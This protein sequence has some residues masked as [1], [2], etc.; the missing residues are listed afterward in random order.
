M[1]VWSKNLELNI[2]II[3]KQHKEIFE[4]VNKLLS[5]FEEHNE[6]EETYKA[7][8]FVEEYIRKHFQT[9]EFYLRKYEYNEL[10]EHLKMHQEF[11]VQLSEF[12]QSCKR[13][14]ITEKAALRMTEF[15]TNWWDTHILNVDSKYVPWILDKI[16]KT[17]NIL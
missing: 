7:L 5:S 15:L 11:I 16:K 6:L 1:L 13:A 12:K 14:G 17:E 9:E 3:D 2:D 4:V 8:G 10:E